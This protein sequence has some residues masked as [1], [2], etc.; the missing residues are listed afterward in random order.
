MVALRPRW[1]GTDNVAVVDRDSPPGERPSEGRRSVARLVTTSM[2]SS[3][4]VE[5]FADGAADVPPGASSGK[6]E[7]RLNLTW[8]DSG[9]LLLIYPPA[10]WRISGPRASRAMADR[11]SLRR[12]AVAI[13]PRSVPAQDLPAQHFRFPIW[14]LTSIKLFRPLRPRGKR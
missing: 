2:A 1:G 5:L 12:L 11:V 6:S 3:Q 14:D 4:A 8:F 9:S 13:Y 10:A 7:S